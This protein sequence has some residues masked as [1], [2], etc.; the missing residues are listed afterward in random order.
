[1][2]QEN[3]VE[4]TPERKELYM[5]LQL[6]GI[7]TTY[8]NIAKSKYETKT[9]Y[10]LEKL[11]DTKKVVV[12]C[13]VGLLTRYLK[14]MTNNAEKYSKILKKVMNTCKSKD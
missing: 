13:M 8:A 10:E 7:A 14:R 9:E 5:E 11:Y 1:M 4:L 6:G 2:T 3:K 12:V